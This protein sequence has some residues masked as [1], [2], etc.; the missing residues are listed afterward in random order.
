MEGKYQERSR[1]TQ[2]Y[3][4]DEKLREW[5]ANKTKQTNTQL[6]TP[7]LNNENSFA[8]NNSTPNISLSF[9]C[10]KTLY[11]SIKKADLHLPK[12]QTKKL[13]FSKGLPQNT[14]LKINLKENWK[15]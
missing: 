4:E 8:T 15:S 10:K 5:A 11:R 13:R 7:Q 1:K 3:K 2:N 6:T 9:S 12:S 14:K